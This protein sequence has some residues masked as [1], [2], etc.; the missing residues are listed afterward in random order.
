M[1]AALPK[2]SLRGVTT[3][4]ARQDGRRQ[5]AERSQQAVVA[6]LLDLYR[7][8][9]LRPSA[10][11][12]AARSG[13]SERTVFR[14]FDDMEAL[15]ALAMQQQWARVS[16]LFEPPE[17]G[18]DR[19][20]RIAALVAQRLAVFAEIAPLARVAQ[21]RAPFSP[22]I[23]HGIEYRGRLL[24]DQVRCQFAAEL[25][26]LPPAEREELLSALDAATSIETLE[27]LHGAQGRPLDEAG[28]ILTRTVRALLA[29]AA[30]GDR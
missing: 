20:Q 23:R 15:A 5:R 14:L 13:V 12:I 1:T 7:A 26:A 29:D 24:R 30:R 10:Q 25:E 9:N 17:A 19:T 21:L 4:R 3:E 2:Y 8:G 28:R 27:L 16:H 22:A 6:A 18:G 11:E